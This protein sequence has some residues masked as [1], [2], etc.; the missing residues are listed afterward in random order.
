VAKRF[1]PLP[2]ALFDSDDELS[3]VAIREGKG[4]MDVSRRIMR[5]PLGGSPA[6]RHVRAHEMAH[7]KYS[8]LK[9]VAPKSVAMVAIQRAEDMRMN[10]YCRRQGLDEAMDA[11]IVPA[12]AVH[13]LIRSSELDA[14]TAACSGYRTGDFEPIMEAIGVYHDSEFADRVAA[15]VPTLWANLERAGNPEWSDAI[16]NAQAMCDFC[17]R[18]KDEPEPDSGDSEPDSSDSEE[19]DSEESD[20]ST[21]SDSSDEPGEDEPG[22]ESDDSDDGSG[23]SSDPDDG[24]ESEPGEATDL[25][26]GGASEEMVEIDLSSDPMDKA[27]DRALEDALPP[28]PKDPVEAG[29]EI[30]ERNLQ[31][32]RGDVRQPK[33]TVTEQRMPLRMPP[34][35]RRGRSTVAADSGRVPRYMGRYCTDKAVFAGRGKR[36]DN[37]GAILI[38]T[39]GSMSLSSADI[40]AIMEAAPMGV[41]AAYSGDYGGGHLWIIA[42]NGKRADAKHLD[43][44][45]L[46]NMVDVPAL[47]WLAKQ[48]GEKFW[49]CDGVVTGEGDRTGR[50]IIQR[51]MDLCRKHRIVRVNDLPEL[52]RTMETHRRR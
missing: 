28:E 22:E 12:D 19:S 4:E 30:L 35:K 15:F 32:F 16:A 44:P 2:E 48:D 39:S 21:G 14:V 33:M 42:R 5:V 49:L 8:P 47:E 18:S 29:M 51:C 52:L 24:N 1:Y 6:D 23:S 46:G 43:P 40:D 31:Y 13:P 45:G 20:D 27:V 7:A 36:R 3:V 41:I 38:D 9:P 11:P 34:S 50:N 10:L 25:G 17:D 26:T 37:G